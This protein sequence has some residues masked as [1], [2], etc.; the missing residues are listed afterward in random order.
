MNAPIRWTVRLLAAA[1][2]LLL[3][4]A[5]ADAATYCVG[6][7]PGCS[8]TSTTLSAAITTATGAGS[9]EDDVIRIGSGTFA[10]ADL[11]V[12]SNANG[13][14]L[15][16]GQGASGGAATVFT[17][18]TAEAP[19]NIS[20]AEA[21]IQDLRVE[22]PAGANFDNGMFLSRGRAD[23]I[24]VAESSGNN[25]SGVTMALGAVLNASA[26][27]MGGNNGIAV[28]A[29]NVG[30]ATVQDSTLGA[31]IGVAGGTD[32]TTSVL[33]TKVSA[34]TA[35]YSFGG[36]MSVD[37]SAATLVRPA[38]C[39]FASGAAAEL[40]GDGTTVRSLNVRNVTAVAKTP[41]FAGLRLRRDS[42]TASMSAAVRSSLFANVDDA[43]VITGSAPLPTAQFSASGIEPAGSASEA[44]PGD[45][46][47]FD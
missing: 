3:A 33:R 12:P 23:R 26:V 2:A 4:P 42:G 15:I 1:A 10:G 35:F 29:F 13:S 24:V 8:G 17:R 31:C 30:D 34:T 36:S 18:T 19:P 16:V 40:S 5:A 45:E 27:A 7:P 37:S 21:T 6:S 43:L 28:Q 22:V 47:N 20:D 9:P 11:Q 32:G 14:L 25:N 44:S 41:G 39:T 46:P 38:A